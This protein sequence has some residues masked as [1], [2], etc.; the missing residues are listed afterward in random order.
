MNIS[1]QLRQ[2]LKHRSRNATIRFLNAKLMFDR[3]ISHLTS[4]LH[5]S[6]FRALKDLRSHMRRVPGPVGNSVTQAWASV[7][8]CMAIGFNRT[9]GI[10]RDSNGFRNGLD[11]IGVLGRIDDGGFL[12]IPNLG[13]RFEWKPG[14]LGAFDG[15]DLAHEV[16]EWNGLYRVTI[17]SF[18]RSSSWRGLQLPLKVSA[19]TLNQLTNNLE[20]SSGD[21]TAAGNVITRRHKR[22]RSS[23]S[24]TMGHGARRRL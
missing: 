4:T 5:W 24:Y 12:C 16:E 10:H 8:P 23:V 11:M 9:T 15:Y 19:P 13:L 2:A 21:K 22:N 1:S 20:Q 17:I 7:F 14:C 3:H 6:L 18:C